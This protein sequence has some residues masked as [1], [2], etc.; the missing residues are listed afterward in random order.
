MP[1]MSP[2]MWTLIMM[3]TM[4]MMMTSSSWMFFLKEN[5]VNMKITKKSKMK[6]MEW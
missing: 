3:L 2:T 5:N 4:L 1:Q 6:K